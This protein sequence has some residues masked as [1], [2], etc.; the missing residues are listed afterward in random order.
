MVSSILIILFSIVACLESTAY[1][2]YEL[3]VNKNKV[4]WNCSIYFIY[5]TDLFFLL[6]FILLLKFYFLMLGK[7]P[8]SFLDCGMLLH[9]CLSPKYTKNFIVSNA[10]ISCSILSASFTFS[11]ICLSIIAMSL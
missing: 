4:R 6:L 9:Y 3:Q 2:F 1:G 7:I 8:Q 5:C 10:S 11:F